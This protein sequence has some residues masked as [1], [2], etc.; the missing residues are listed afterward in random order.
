SL[1]RIHHDPAQPREAPTVPLENLPEP[2]RVPLDSAATGAVLPP[3]LATD[4]AGRGG[5]AIVRITD[6]QGAGEV[7]YEDVRDRI[8]SQLAQELAI[9]RYVDRLKRSAYVEVRAL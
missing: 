1:Q 8:R 3:F 6:R 2:Y 4:Q 7:R 5:Y 9:R